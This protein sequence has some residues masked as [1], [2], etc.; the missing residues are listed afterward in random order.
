MNKVEGKKRLEKFY[1]LY[2]MYLENLASM[3]D[4]CRKMRMCDVEEEYDS[5][6]SVFERVKERHLDLL[7][8]IETDYS[9]YFVLAVQTAATVKPN[10]LKDMLWC[11]EENVYFFDTARD[12]AKL[13]EE[14]CKQGHRIT[15]SYE[16]VG[17]KESEEGKTQELT[18]VAKGCDDDKLKLKVSGK[19][20]KVFGGQNLLLRMVLNG[21]F[22][23]NFYENP[24]NSDNW[25]AEFEVV[26]TDEIKQNIPGVNILDYFV[27]VNLT[28]E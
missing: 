19:Y 16:F 7:D 24:D 23:L 5:L 2:D 20:L 26:A 10:M 14:I 6:W 11:P 9:D 15:L 12:T 4:V 22:D 1:E 3:K 8:R 18:V 25:C 13:L 27:K 17:A 21:V 28:V